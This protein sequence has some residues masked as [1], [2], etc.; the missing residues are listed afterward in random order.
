[1]IEPVSHHTL[2]EVG[3]PQKGAV[4]RRGPTQYQMVSTTG[5]GMAAVEHE[6]FRPQTAQP[7]LFVKG[8]GDFNRLAPTG[9]GM[10]VDLKH[11]GVRGELDLSQARVVRRRIAFNQNR[12]LEFGGGVLNGGEQVDVVFGGLHRRNKNP[13]P[14]LARF[15]R[16]RRPHHGIRFCFR[17]GW[18]LLRR[19]RL[20]LLHKLR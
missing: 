12:H 6:F 1:M 16:Q 7:R 19:R 18:R 10:N 5:A 17:G 20:L 8:V 15:H 4:R 2:Q 3:T 11:A 9:R 14:A 13:Q